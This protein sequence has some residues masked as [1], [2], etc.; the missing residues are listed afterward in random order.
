MKEEQPSEKVDA[1]K[2]TKKQPK[3]FKEILTVEEN[4]AR[5]AT[6]PSASLGK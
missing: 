5:L 6:L 2:M 1:A 3:D 4:E